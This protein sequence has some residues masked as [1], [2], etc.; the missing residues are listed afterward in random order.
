MVRLFFS[1]TLEKSPRKCLTLCKN[2]SLSETLYFES[3]RSKFTLEDTR[4]AI[5][6][7]GDDSFERL[8]LQVW[9]LI[10]TENL[11]WEA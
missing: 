2:F 10:L 3:L 11:K 6:A 9:W 7:I 8:T 4:L 5:V 1:I